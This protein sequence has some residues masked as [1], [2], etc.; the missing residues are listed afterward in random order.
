MKTRH[1]LLLSVLLIWAQVFAPSLTGMAGGGSALFAQDAFYI[2][3]NDGD[4]NG[5]FFDEVKRMGYSKFDLDSI[6]HDIY[7]VQEIELADTTYRIPLA[8][9]DS[10]GFQQPE[11][12]FNPKVKLMRDSGLLPYVERA[13]DG[14]VWFYDLPDNLKPQIG[15]VLIGL[16]TDEHNASFYGEG[17]G[18]FSCVVESFETDKWDS[19]HICAR[20]R[21]V[22]D[23]N[24]VFEQYI[25]VEDLGYDEQGNLVRR[26]VAGMPHREKGETG[27]INLIH[28]QGTIQNEWKPDENASISLA[29]DV[30]VV[31]RVR[32]A[33]KI[34]WK[35]FFVK[36]T[37]EL[38]IDA[39]PSVSTSV[40]RGFDVALGNTVAGFGIPLRIWFPTE[41]PIFELEPYPDW[42]I[43]G[44][45][46]LEAKF[47]FPKIHIG[48]GGDIIFD[49][50][51]LFPIDFG[52]HWVP[53][54]AKDGDKLIDIGSTN[55]SLSGFLQT[56]LKFQVNIGTARWFQKLFKCQL[57]ANIY[58]GPK[59][60][61]A[62]E[63][64][65]DWLNNEG[66]NLYNTLSGSSINA[67]WLSLDVNAGTTASVLWGDELK[68][69]FYS[70]NYPF[71]CD[72]LRLIPRIEPKEIE[73]SEKT[74]TFT[75]KTHKDIALGY[76]VMD[77]IL[78]GNG[79]ERNVGHWAYSDKD[80]DYTNSF[81]ISDLKAGSY[82]INRQLY[83]AGHGPFNV[84]RSFVFNVPYTLEVY[85]DQ[86]NFDAYG[87]ETINHDDNYN[88]N[89]AA[90]D[91]IEFTTN[92]PK[93]EIRVGYRMSNRWVVY[94]S[95]QVI[96]EDAGRYRAIFKALPNT[97]LWER[98]AP[99]G[100]GL[101]IAVGSGQNAKSHEIGVYQKEMPLN[102]V[103]VK[104]SS[105]FI[106]ENGTEQSGGG[107]GMY[108]QIED[109]YRLFVEAP[110]T[111]TRQG[112]NSIKI[113]G[114]SNDNYQSVYDQW[115]VTFEIK[116]DEQGQTTFENGSC[117][118]LTKHYYD[119]TDTYYYASTFDGPIPAYQYHYYD[120]YADGKWLTSA[121]Y[122][123]T[124]HRT[125][126]ENGEWVVDTY[127]KNGSMQSTDDNRIY[128]QV[129]V[130]IPE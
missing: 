114:I 86:L 99:K 60:D 15:D 120:Y 52:L 95:L 41:C 1:K 130:G 109:N 6:E 17:K 105:R 40:S 65:T 12:K 88:G 4:F 7:V 63:F 68:K 55:V 24:E 121:N 124:I 3:R 48:I 118:Q 100:E 13:G 20:G 56:G 83:W 51:R 61:G 30:D 115:N 101:Y 35:S 39:T 28:L 92:S 67:T 49:T 119:Y 129:K 27:N 106:D 69:T 44:E 36:L 64:S 112:K 62:M 97:T 75:M 23:I 74:A 21:E 8:A 2:Y 5:F 42:F 38:I 72:T 16:P 54:E 126:M 70:A 34:G 19:R 122:E 57:G 46:K 47:K 93:N 127:T 110:V 31:F 87:T 26:R 71:F 125:H 90:V 102:N 25:T 18:G 113:Q 104:V 82:S 108:H 33:Y 117:S 84:Y 85:K 43:R 94:D 79:I 128:I 59:I 76:T 81:S 32:L 73:V 80:D 53:E 50:N 9:I 107:Y 58:A 10:I 78:A 123:E 11:I 111:A 45:G 116:R 22:E 103:Y 89:Q 14:Y 91:Y 29:A 96:D 98:K 37:K 66:L 77:F